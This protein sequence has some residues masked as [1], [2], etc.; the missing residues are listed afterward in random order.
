MRKLKNGY[1]IVCEECGGASHYA[2]IQP[3]H[4]NKFVTQC[5]TAKAWNKRIEA[6]NDTDNDD[7]E[8]VKELSQKNLRR[9]NVCIFSIRLCDNEIDRDFERFT[10]HTLE[11]LAPMFVGKAGIFDHQ[12]SAIGQ[13]ARIYKTEIVREP[14]RLTKAGDGYCWLK[15]YAY[16]VRTENNQE[17]IAE[18]EGG[19]KKEVSVGCAIRRSICSICGN[20]RN[21][22]DCGH[23]KG[24]HYDG[25]LC[26]ANLEGAIDAYE[27]AFVLTPHNNC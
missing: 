19:I 16:M 6:K 8:L 21:E 14:E 3:W 26:Y 17:L 5:Q 27:W 15:G 25:K 4:D 18:I 20:D 11:D 1:R 24:Q 12:W 7:F 23:Q 22:S 9:E 13:A 2:F 10:V